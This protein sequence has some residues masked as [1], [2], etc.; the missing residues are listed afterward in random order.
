MDKDRRRN[1][2]KRTVT[3]GVIAYNEHRYLHDL[4]QD[5]LDQTYPKDVT[6]IILVDGESSDDTWDIMQTFG[7]KYGDQYMGI[8][9]LKNPKRIQPAGWNVVIQNSCADILLRVDAHARLP[10]D[11]IEKNV[12]CI[13]SGEFVCGGPREN[14]MDE[15]TPWKRML[16][17]AEQSLF[18]AGIAAYRQ[19]TE[20]K[21]YVTS[22]F[23]GA[24][25]KEVLSRVGLFNEKLIRTE[26][27]EY[28]YR[29]RQAGFRICYDP[30]IHSYYQTR[31]SFREML[32]QKYLNGF[33]IGKTL[34]VC[35][36][37]ISL[38]HLVPTGFVWGMLLTA[39]LCACSVTWPA[40][41][42]W[43]VYGTVNIFMSLTAFLSEKNL[44]CVCLPVLFF[45]L[46]MSY[47]VG[48]TLGIIETMGKKLGT[49]K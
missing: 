45:L 34:F 22:V 10:R 11:F 2:M 4:L 47:G 24:Y 39:A 25:C 38:F 36:G 3:V 26:D 20:T 37:C 12:M 33:W 35:P 14:I 48:T 1:E 16:L 6:E 46:H 17:N 28:H 15:N 41:T 21:S 13:N 18:G 31:N 42:F 32:K 44:A 19:K 23:L 8:K 49:M 30:T 29:I 5:V 27:N 7:D 40:I 43:I 9:I